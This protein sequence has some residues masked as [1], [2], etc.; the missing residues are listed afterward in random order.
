MGDEKVVDVQGGGNL[1]GIRGWLLFF[2]ICFIIVAIS[3]LFTSFQVFSKPAMI[4]ASSNLFSAIG[5]DGSPV[6]FTPPSMYL[7][8]LE[9]LLYL[10]SLIILVIALVFIFQKKKKGVVWII[11]HLWVYF[12][13]GII[14]QLIDISWMKPIYDQLQDGV[15]GGLFGGFTTSLYS[16]LIMSSVFGIIVNG[17]LTWYFLKSKRVNATLIN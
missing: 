9:F 15:I 3:L 2:V 13:V 1:N 14:V 10:I 4:Q 12:I 11:T 7:L 17:L 5:G 8:V 6:D 16:S